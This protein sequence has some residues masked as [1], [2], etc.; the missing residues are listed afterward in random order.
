MTEDDKTP[1]TDQLPASG[2]NL[3]FGRHTCLSLG[4][5]HPTVPQVF[6]LWQTC[7]DNVDP[8]IKLFRAPLVQQMILEAVDDLDNIPKSTEALMFAI[9]LSSANSMN[10]QD[11][12]KMMG[13]SKAALL[14]KFSS[15]TQQALINAD[16]LKSTN[17]VVL[18]ALTLYL[19]SPPFQISL[20]ECCLDSYCG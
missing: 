1:L 12:Q 17:L 20:L 2:E 5:L 3:I 18:Q 10:E 7:I 19:V 8:L 4:T 11:C 6:G 16:F 9:Y 15:A 14:A 13:E